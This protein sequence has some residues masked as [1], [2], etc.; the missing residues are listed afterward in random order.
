MEV[1][2]ENVNADINKTLKKYKYND[3]AVYLTLPP[4]PP[5]PPA[6]DPKKRAAARQNSIAAPFCAL[7]A[8]LQP[9]LSLQ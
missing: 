7:A 5:L 3:R 4:P 8:E 9:C 2:K 6:E 1:D